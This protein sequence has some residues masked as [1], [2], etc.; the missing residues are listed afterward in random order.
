[1][2]RGLRTDPVGHPDPPHPVR[3]A[4]RP[5]MQPQPYKT[6]Y[7]TPMTP[8]NKPRDQPIDCKAG[9]KKSANPDPET[10]GASSPP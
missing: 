9:E 1:M 5:S 4:L 8:K 6:H 3:H 10:C 7:T 2:A